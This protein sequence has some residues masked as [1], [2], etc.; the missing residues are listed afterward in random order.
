MSLEQK[1]AEHQTSQWYSLTSI[2][3][4]TRCICI[5]SDPIIFKNWCKRNTYQLSVTYLS[6]RPSVSQVLMPLPSPQTDP[7]WFQNI[8]EVT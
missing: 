2:L 3:Q 5:L 8:N 6:E 4:S 1:R 7:N